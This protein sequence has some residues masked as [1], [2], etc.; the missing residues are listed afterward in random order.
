MARIKIEKAHEENV[1]NTR[2]KTETMSKASHRRIASDVTGT[3]PSKSPIHNPG[4]LFGNGLSADLPLTT[5]NI[6]A[7]TSKSTS[8][9]DAM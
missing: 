7:S 8:Q 5:R 1:K 6:N 4:A 2:A 9:I 3:M